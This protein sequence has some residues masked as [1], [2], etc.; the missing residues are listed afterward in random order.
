MKSNKLFRIILY[1]IIVAAS[2][3]IVVKRYL[4]LGNPVTNIYFQYIILAFFI[5]FAYINLRI[6]IK[7]IREYRK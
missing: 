3:Y 6:L 4:D 2:I 5:I 1:V 7:L